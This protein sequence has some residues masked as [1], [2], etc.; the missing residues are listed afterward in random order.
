MPISREHEREERLARVWDLHSRGLKQAEIALELGWSQQQVSIDIRHL[1]SQKRFALSQHF[2][3]LPSQYDTVISKLEQIRTD[4]WKAVKTT[5]SPR[6]KAV[7]YS[8][9][10]SVNE[11]YLEVLSLND[12]ILANVENA[13]KLVEEAKANIKEAKEQILKATAE[14]EEE[15]QSLPR[16]DDADDIESRVRQRVAVAMMEEESNGESSSTTNDSS[17]D[18]SEPQASDGNDVVVVVDDAN[19][20][21]DV[22]DV[23]DGEESLT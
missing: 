13:E 12:I 1:K 17:S 11:K 21:N 4:V 23:N 6:D 2:R 3:E 19:D 10:I 16:P 22:N 14:E 15:E 18:S 20:A 9:L 8:V 5:T 7:L